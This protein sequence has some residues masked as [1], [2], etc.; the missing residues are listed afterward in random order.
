MDPNTNDFT[1]LVPIDRQARHPGWSISRQQLNY[2]VLVMR[3]ATPLTST[4]IAKPIPINTNT[5]YPSNNQQLKAYGFGVTENEV[6]S[7]Y[8]READVT[9]INNDKCW[10]RGISFNNVLKSEEVMCTDPFGGTT[11]TC[12]GDS[13]GP[14]TDATGSTLVGVISFGS[15]CE[16]DNI[17]DGHVRLSEVSNWVQEQICSLSANPPS[18]CGLGLSSRV[19][20]R[21]VPMVIDFSHD[22][23]PEET[24][25]A[26]RSKETQE[27][28]YAGPE[29]IPTR[30]G[31]HKSIMFLLPGE[32]TFEVHDIK[33]NGLVSDRGN[34]SWK[35]FQESKEVASGG[36]SFKNQQVTKFVVSEGTVSNNNRNSAGN[37]EGISTELDECLVK[38]EL[39]ITIGAMYSTSCDCAPNGTSGQIQLACMDANDQQCGANYD[40][41]FDSSYCCSGRRCSNNQCRSSAPTSGSRNDS[42]ISSRGD[43]SRLERD[44]G[45]LR[46][47]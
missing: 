36:P 1:R 9:Y 26:V 47:R 27:T 24:T 23:Y 22:F 18:S 11:A 14:L 41:C 37:S 29:Y 3:L 34:G 32:Y 5:N 8:L 31:N 16:A 15:G 21:A 43:A 35:I 19:A 2:D 13:G 12:L 7:Q 28:V 44:S 33:G 4:D 10:G 42:K 20:S 39:E 17:P 40:T 6:V 45:N 30:N 25:F 38:K 46:R